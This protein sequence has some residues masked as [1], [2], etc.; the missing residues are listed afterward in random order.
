MIDAINTMKS[1]MDN[2]VITLINNSS[3]Y[4][5]RVESNGRLF[6]I[7]ET[8]FNC[9]KLSD[10][11][12]KRYSIESQHLIA[13]KLTELYNAIILSSKSGDSQYIYANTVVFSQKIVCFIAT[14]LK[15]FFKKQLLIIL[16]PL[17]VLSSF[18]FA[19]ITGID[20]IMLT[21]WYDIA[22]TYVILLFMLVIHEFG[23]S[24]ASLYYGVKPREIGF[25]FYF[26]F[27]MLYANVTDTW[28]LN[29]YKR[30]MVSFAGVYFQLIVNFLLIIFYLFN[31][32]QA[33]AQAIMTSNI[34]C[35]Y[36]LIPFFR[37]D[38]YWIYADFFEKPNL[39]REHKFYFLKLKKTDKIDYVLLFFS[40]GNTIFIM[41]VLYLYTVIGVT[42]YNEVYQIYKFG[43]YVLA[44]MLLTL[45]KTIIY[46]VFLMLYIKNIYKQIG[47]ITIKSK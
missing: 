19:I 30:I 27:P 5:I 39:I 28:L 6:K 34:I 33:I 1:L 10:I 26:I 12:D 37:N 36:T 18:A 42:L 44:G 9:L 7:T 38:G 20:A 22:T 41:Y 43:D 21:N 35:L 15:F 14:F 4:Y 46:V 24:T 29:K 2:N 16:I 8:I 45:F 17:V 3:D 47:N 23:H 40:I 31:P 25:G 13:N 32:N 11:D